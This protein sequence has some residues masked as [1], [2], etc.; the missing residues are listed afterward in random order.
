MTDL[1]VR[2]IDASVHGH[3]LVRSGPADHL[4]IGFHGYGENA[5]IHMAALE[6]IPGIEQWTAVAVQALH[7]FYM[8][9]TGAIVAS[10]MTSQDRELAIADNR[11]YVQ[12]VVARF[13]KPRQLVFLGFSQGAA[14]AYRA[15][16]GSSAT[17]IIALAGDLPPEIADSHEAIPPVLIGRGTRE[18]W[19]TEEKLQKDVGYLS[20]V[21]TVKTCIYDGGHEWTNEFREAAGKFL[22]MLAGK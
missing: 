12:S 14:M 20:S 9:R 16:A 13:P 18:E 17:G 2:T 19:Y 7:P 10:W 22:G 6:Q 21:T 1:E 5:E 11:A 8:H 4:L 15:A 3:Y